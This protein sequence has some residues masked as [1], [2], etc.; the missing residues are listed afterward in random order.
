MAV[1]FIV[2]IFQVYPISARTS[3]PVKTIDSFQHDVWTVENGL[4]MNTTMGITQ[5]SNGYIWVGTESGIARFDG[6]KFETFNH[7][8]TPVFSGGV[9]VAL[10]KDREDSLWIGT[11]G[12]GLI[13]YRNGAFRAITADPGLIHND[14][15]AILESRD[16]SIWVG[17][18]SGLCRIANETISKIKLPENLSTHEI[19]SI[20]ED[21]NGRIWVGTNG[22]GLVLVKKRGGG[23]ESEYLG[24]EGLQIV[25]LFEDRKGAVWVGT[26]KN[27]LFR[28]HEDKRTRFSTENGLS[29]T[30][31]RCLFEDRFGNIWIGTYDGGINILPA[32]ENRISAFHNRNEFTSNSITSFFRDREGTLWIGTNGG[33]LNSLRE[34][35]ITTYSTKNGLSYQNVYGVFQDGSGRV[36]AGTKGYG[37]NYF[38]DNRFF[39]LTTK[40]GLSSDSVVAIA[41]TPA[42]TIWFGTLGG[43]IT[44]Y[45]DG[46]FD[47]F[48]LRSGLSY[49][50]FRALYTDPDGNLWAGT[51]QGGVHRFVNGRF[52][53]IAE[54]KARVN[55]FLRDSKGYLWIATFGGGVCRLKPGDTEEGNIEVFDTKKGLT[56]NITLCIHEDEAGII[57]VGAVN[58]LNRF[59]NGVFKGMFKKDGLPDDMVYCILEDHNKN[60]WISCNQ[61]IYCL[62]RK[63][64]EA[65]FKGDISRVTPVLYGKEAGMLSIECNGGNQPAGWKVRDGKLWF[66]T[67]NGISVI[68]PKN[69]GVNNIPPPVKIEKITMDGKDV[70]VPAASCESEPMTVP[71]GT[72]HIEFQY[73]ALSFIVP[74]NIRFKTKLEGYDADWIDAGDSRKAFY[75]NLSPGRY[76][77]RVTAC[78]SDGV[79]NDTGTSV[80][81]YFES[82]FY[83]TAAF[84]ILFLLAAALSVFFFLSYIKRGRHHRHKIRPEPV[85]KQRSSTLSTEETR[86]YVSK[87]KYLIE[88]E[89]VYKDPNLTIKSLASKLIV[90][91]RT[92]SEII[93]DELGKNF[94]EFINESRINEAR[95]ILKNTE[96]RH[97]PIIDIAY[98]VGYN[99]KSAFNRAFKCFTRMTPSQFRKINNGKG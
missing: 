99:S 65:F 6:I 7:E 60:F 49:H 16:G 81:L 56:Q 71:P 66:P 51:I 83:R 48:G 15:W 9:I 5:T 35:K 70:P 68:D 21:R 43:G 55:S 32:G 34:K 1:I 45:K 90:S 39:T 26:I 92:L 59:S 76:N 8:N 11:R 41:E 23:F 88:A 77:F 30:N 53:L 37:V 61:G 42:G 94:Y 12:D 87:L 58:G 85:E 75:N 67:T 18:T 64:V 22:G 2:L 20:L 40:D 98:E 95:R 54:T 17:S 89:S 19:G 96:T 63:E 84:K 52:P 36:W 97:M 25:A 86:A 50:I 4:P 13:R 69:I 93:N 62:C 14:V 74:A 27:G 44:R 82:E 78:N 80:C 33:G 3:P 91:P 38:K 47:V 24:P 79:W 72:D 46:N 31:V 73:T 57:W 28:Y 29:T 10:I